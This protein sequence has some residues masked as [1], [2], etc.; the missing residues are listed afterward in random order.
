M[1]TPPSVSEADGLTISPGAEPATT[2]C[3]AKPRA[4]VKR[5]A[6]EDQE[7]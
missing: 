5:E 4:A 1:R 2:A 6:E 3:S 7:R